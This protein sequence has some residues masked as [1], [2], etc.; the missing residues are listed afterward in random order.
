MDNVTFIVFLSR[1]WQHDRFVTTAK[2]RRNQSPEQHV[3]DGWQDSTGLPTS[4]QYESLCRTT[5]HLESKNRQ[6]NDWQA[7]RLIP[8]LAISFYNR[9]VLRLGIR[10]G[11]RFFLC[12]FHFDPFL[13][14]CIGESPCLHLCPVGKGENHPY[15]N[16]HYLLTNGALCSSM[17][18]VSVLFHTFHSDHKVIDLI[19]RAY[20][21]SFAVILLE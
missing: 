2:F 7:N 10:I 19:L 15:G 9:C 12:L 6:S 5:Q 16:H 13:C 18:I 1:S 8:G 20:N 3:L 11:D 17:H 4:M 14:V 21:T